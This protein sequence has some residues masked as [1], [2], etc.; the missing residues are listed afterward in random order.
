MRILSDG[1]R[2]HMSDEEECVRHGQEQ[3]HPGCDDRRK[4]AEY[5][6]R[7]EMR[8]AR[9]VLPIHLRGLTSSVLSDNATWAAP[10]IQRDRAPCIQPGFRTLG[11]CDA[12][13]HD[14]CVPRP[15]D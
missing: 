1:W 10:G 8:K 13:K 12:R 11:V 3:P 9:V 15:E 6:L 14:E 4:E 5:N 7:Q 2:H